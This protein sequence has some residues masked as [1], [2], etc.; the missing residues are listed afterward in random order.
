MKTGLDMS[1]RCIYCAGLS[2]DDHFSLE[3][4]WPR[5]LGGSFCPALFQTND[6]CR[7][8][9]SRI[10]QW[11]DGAFLKNWFIHAE[12]GLSAQRYLD[13]ERPGAVPLVYMGFDEN[14][15][16][17]ESEVCER[18]LG[19]SGE[20][21]YHIHSRDDERWATFAGG[22]FI[23]RKSG[24]FGRAYIFLTSL[25]QYWSLTALIS[26]SDHFSHAKRRCLTHIVGLP[27]EF[28]ILQFDEGEIT[29]DERRE[30]AW[31]MNRPDGSTLA[32]LPMRV[33]FSDRFLAKL[34]LG[35]AHNI[36]GQKT[37]I[38]PYSEQL[39]ALLWTRDPGS[40][41][42][43]SVRGSGFWDGGLDEKVTQIASRRGAWT[44]HLSVLGQALGYTLWTPAGRS[45]SMMVSDDPSR[46]QDSVLRNY[47]DGAV[48]FI[49]PQRRRCLG[50]VSIIDLVASHL[51]RRHHPSLAELASMESEPAEF[52]QKRPSEPSD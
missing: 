19:P 23:R 13:P 50:P 15:P 27:T 7:T 46:W 51:G 12:I 42:G 9:N 45:M 34:A 38:S 40:R 10:G 21:I 11:V 29:P 26:F 48:Y 8:C 30:I 25:S 17:A 1:F 44:L 20:H 22:D 5:A 6:V 31:I 43:L 37:D 52:P 41:E 49:V 47:K 36:C 39:R 24:D 16:V 33:D 3:H 28:K 2:K 14:V 35:F 18:W 4:I 32:K